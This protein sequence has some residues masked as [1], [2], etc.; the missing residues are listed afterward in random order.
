MNGSKD[1]LVHCI[2]HGR[3]AAD[4]AAA[5]LAKTDTLLCDVNKDDVDTYP[6]DSDGKFEDDVDTYPFDSDGKFEDD[7]TTVDDE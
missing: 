4:S 3:M 1:N 7:E 5:I 2:K 6:F